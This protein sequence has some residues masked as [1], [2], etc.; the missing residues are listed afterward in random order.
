MRY[1]LF[2]IP[3]LLAVLLFACRK[4]DSKLPYGFSKIY[5]PQA[6]LQSGGVNNNY[7]VPSGT[8]SSTYN[9]AIDTKSSR[10]NVILGANLSGPASGAYSVDILADNDTLQQLFASGVF[11][12]ATYKPMPSSMYTLPA[13]LSV[14]QGARGGTFDLGLDIGALKSDSFAGKYLVLA[15]KISNPTQYTLD[16]ALSTTIVVVNVNSLVI[17]PAVNITTQ[18]IQNPGNPFGASAWDGTR[19]GTLADWNVNPAA[20]GHNGLGGYSSDGDGQTMDL[21]SGWG[22]P[23]IYNGKIWQTLNLP[24]GTYGFDPSGGTW[25]WQGTLDPTYAVVAPGS[26]TLP[27][28][29]KILNNSAIMYQQIVND[30]QPKVS[31]TLSAPAKVAVGIVINYVQTDQGFKSTQ[32]TLYNYPKHL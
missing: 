22:S 12:T 29:S 10:L 20:S 25:K 5:M 26:D 8:D 21:E 2:I 23:Q 14:P 30:P 4:D 9:Y 31:F 3:G 7:P 17:G 24:A 6:I 1:N 16:T 32:V 28:Y 18:H 27:D 19:W 13:Q 11:D 15:V